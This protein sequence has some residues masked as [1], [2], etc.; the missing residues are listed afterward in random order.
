MLPDDSP[1]PVSGRGDGGDGFT[2]A[3]KGGSFVAADT[4][5]IVVDSSQT[6]GPI[7]RIWASIGYDELNWTATPRGKAIHRMLGGDVF[8]AG[9]YWVR[10]HNGFTSGNGWSA[11]AWGAGNPYHEMPDG[12]V[13]YHWDTLDAAYDAIIEPG[14]FPLVELGFMPRDL[15]RTTAEEATFRKNDL[16]REPYED[17]VWKQ[18][19]KDLDRWR[20]LVH[21]FVAHVVERYGEEHVAQWRFELWNE[22]DM[23]NY[24]HGTVDEYAALYDASYDGAKSAFPRAQVGGPGTTGRGMDFLEQFLAHVAGSER[25]PDFLSFH[26]KGGYFTPRRLYNPFAEVAQE[27][28]STQKM[29]DDIRNNMAIIEAVSSLADLPVYIDECDPAVGTIY[30]V[31]DNPNFVVTNS[32]HY[33]SFVCHLVGKLLDNEPRITLITQWAFYFEG[34]RWFEGNRTLVDN[35]NVEKPIV[36]GLR[37]LER[38]AGGERLVLRSETPGVGGLAVRNG[39]TTRLLLWHHVDEWWE[40]GSVDVQLQLPG[41]TGGKGQVWRLDR[42]HANTFRTWE[43]M[44][45]PDDPSSDDLARIRQSGELKPESITMVETTLSL[46]IPVHGLAFIEMTNG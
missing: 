7:P 14:G 31:Y 34:K 24:W 17:G 44:G 13:R 30:G 15:S 19:P 12:S 41:L 10:M 46:A 22:P 37:L 42:D 36:N 39:E 29:L 16:G 45:R 38:L 1:L 25:R 43:G 9:P 6:L 32:E 33:P 8:T 23:R 2:L 40:T 4:A 26:T 11:P 3:S 27:T 5:T 28:P 20:Q 21:D 35:E 18:P